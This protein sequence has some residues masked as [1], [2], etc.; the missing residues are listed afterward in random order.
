M[1]EEWVRLWS[2]CLPGCNVQVNLIHLNVGDLHHTART[3]QSQ[4]RQV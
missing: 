2:V 1:S 3:A 4:R